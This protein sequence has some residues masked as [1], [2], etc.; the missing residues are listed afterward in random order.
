[1]IT[2]ALYIVAA[3]IIF[4]A[5][6]RLLWHFSTWHQD[7]EETA[8]YRREGR[9]KCVCG[10]RRDDHIWPGFH[11]DTSCRLCRGT[12]EEYAR[13]GNPCP[14]FRAVRERKPI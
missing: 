13:I 9:Q 6:R 7:H 14:N 5:A 11:E 2:L 3:Y 12:D 4:V 8:F 10:H 1:M